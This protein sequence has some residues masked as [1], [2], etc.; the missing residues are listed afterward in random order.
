MSDLLTPEDLAEE[1]GVPVSTVMLWNRQNGWP[2]VRVGRR[3]RWTRE[4]LTEILRR[5]SVAPVK[6]AKLP[7]QTSRSAKRSA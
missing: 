5:Q 6:Q 2:H 3:I 1:F 4:Q 7:G